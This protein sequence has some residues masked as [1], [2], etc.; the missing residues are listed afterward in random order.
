[1]KKRVLVKISGGAIRGTGSEIFNN[2]KLL[3]LCKQLA[4]LNKTVAVGLV[5]GG[6]NI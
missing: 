4:V 6:G 2:K 1:M 3:D 5:L